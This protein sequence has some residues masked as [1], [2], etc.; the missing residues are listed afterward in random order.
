MHT[1]SSPSILPREESCANFSASR[2]TVPTADTADLKKYKQNK[3]KNSL[4][5]TCSPAAIIPSSPVYPSLSPSLRQCENID[6]TSA[7]TLPIPNTS[8]DLRI[9]PSKPSARSDCT[10]FLLSV[11]PLSLESDVPSSLHPSALYPTTSQH[12]ITPSVL[13]GHRIS[14]CSFLKTAYTQA[15]AAHRRAAAISFPLR[16]IDGFLLTICISFII[17]FM[18]VKVC[19]REENA[20]ALC[21]PHHPA[22]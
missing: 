8:L 15:T 21:S 4:S 1:A 16:W 9:P 3:K 17:L 13:T 22:S 14:L 11:H 18:T 19:K 12:P 10:H 20:P 5:L 2:A 7:A 6:E